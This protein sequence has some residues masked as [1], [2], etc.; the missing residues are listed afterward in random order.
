MSSRPDQAPE[1]LIQIDGLSR[2]ALE[3]A[4][5]R[6][7]I[8]VLQRLIEH[9]RFE[10]RSI[11]AGLPS[12]TP[13]AQAELFYGVRCAVPAFAFLDREARTPRHM[14]A[15]GAASAVERRLR[16][17]D[18]GPLLRAG[19]AYCDIYTGGARVCRFC[20]S[21]LADPATVFSGGLAPALRTI[22]AYFGISGR[23]S[24][25]M[26]GEAFR[27]ISSPRDRDGRSLRA[28]L[29]DSWSRVLASIVLRDSSRLNAI[30]DMRDGLPIVHVNFVGYDKQAHR[31]GPRSQPA[32][33][34][35]QGADRAIGTMIQAA[36]DLAGAPPTIVIYSDHG[37]ERT[38]SFRQAAGRGLGALVRDSARQVDLGAGSS[39]DQ[40][41][42]VSRHTLGQEAGEQLLGI[43]AEVEQV[44]GQQIVAIESGP[45]AHIYLTGPATDEARCD[46]AARVASTA[47]QIAV[48]ARRSEGPPVCFLG[49]D[50]YKDAAEL[51][52]ARLVEHPFA[53]G[54]PDDLETLAAHHSAGDL[55]LLA[56]GFGA[57]LSFASE[58]GSHGGCGPEETHAFALAPR[59]LLPDPA[60]EAPLRL[61]DLRSAL[62]HHRKD[63]S[64][65]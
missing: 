58:R 13:A 43:G 15:P 27:F 47:G 54:V 5:G 50:R 2:P 38:S 35:L 16:A 41:R 25:M 29:K 28:A 53:A 14:L 17:E 39:P 48:L 49:E 55:I 65:P 33:R 20:P 7:R 34:A 23:A 44:G 51:C 62:L 52:S 40:D 61:G 57:A 37:Q 64:G 9:D 26:A 18:G 6:G 30:R 24:I 19:A 31:Y 8:P 56:T 60:A 45:I 42:A 46:L 1:L 32:L 22:G 36:R 10:L 63:R 59:G 12:T 4:L 11:Y 3:G 21:S